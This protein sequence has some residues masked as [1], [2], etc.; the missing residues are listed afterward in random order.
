[1]SGKKRKIYASAYR[2][3]AARLVINTGRAHAV[4][5]R[6]I[7]VGE[8]LLGRWIAI[9]R[10][11][12]ARAR[13]AVAVRFVVPARTPAA[14]PLPGAHAAGVGGDVDVLGFFQALMLP[15][16]STPDLLGGMLSLLH[17]TMAV[18]KPL[19]WDTGPVSARVVDAAPILTL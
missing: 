1:M 18:P 10:S 2:R 16:R 15:S 11:A 5:S 4:V 3:D 8:Q 13:Q 12:G 14:G 7:V 17:A 9:E 6:E 19:L